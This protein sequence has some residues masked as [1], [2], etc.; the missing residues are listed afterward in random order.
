M[1]ATERPPARRGESLWPNPVI[2]QP[3]SQPANQPAGPPHGPSPG[4]GRGRDGE[5]ES[6]DPLPTLYTAAPHEGLP[7]EPPVFIVESVPKCKH[8]QVTQTTSMTARR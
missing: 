4:E 1:P 6:W 8:D 2:S 7:P 5:L 3:A